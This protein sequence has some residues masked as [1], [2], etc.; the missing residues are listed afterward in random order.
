MYEQHK[1]L[2]TPPKYKEGTIRT[3]RVYTEEVE[4]YLKEIMREEERKDR[5]FGARHKQ[6]LTNVQIHHKLIEAGFVISLGTVNGALSRLRKQQKEVFI[7]QQYDMGE[8]L[9]Y[10]F[11]EVWMDC[12]EGAKVYHMAVFSSPGG[13]F[14]WLYLYTNQKQAVFMDSHVKFFEMM[15]G[16]YREVVYDNMRNV[17][18]KFIGKNEKELNQELVD[19]SLYYGFSVN[20][21]NC[22]KG[23]E[24]GHVEGSVK[25]L[26]NKLFADNW[27]FNSLEDAQTYAYS[28]LLKMN[29]N[30]L[31]E[32]EK[33][34][35]NT[36]RPPLELAVVSEAKVNT[37]SMIQ[38][39]YV[40]YSV[41]EYLWVNGSQ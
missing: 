29:E 5:L 16:A 18:K 24:K 40:F 20:V 2:L 6:R 32:E 22:F 30:S 37:C 3:K 1:Q 39:D 9:E 11:G 38:V 41:P 21:T 8:R 13:K 31:M 25:V 36:Y 33:K 15:G 12:G 7:C 26:R 23:N 4:E 28:Q 10:D 14:R 27:K 34:H 17:V 35:L 19:M